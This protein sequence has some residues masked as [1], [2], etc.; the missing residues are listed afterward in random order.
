MIFGTD[1]YLRFLGKDTSDPNETEESKSEVEIR[2]RQPVVAELL[3]QLY[4]SVVTIGKEDTMNLT[5]LI[6]MLKL[7]GKSLEDDQKATNEEGSSHLQN[8]MDAIFLMSKVIKSVMY[9]ILKY[10]F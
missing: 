3:Y 7:S 10:L 9:W 8:I 2:K 4:R 1:L 6:D 5:T